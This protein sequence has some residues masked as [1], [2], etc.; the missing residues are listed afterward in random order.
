MEIERE[1]EGNEEKR[2]HTYMLLDCCAVVLLFVLSLSP[3]G[4]H[5]EFF[6]TGDIYFLLLLQSTLTMQK[7]KE[8]VF[9]G[10]VCS[11]GQTVMD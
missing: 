4:F 5:S 7:K 8:K 2:N 3:L 6:G 10:F 1:G 11:A 9:T